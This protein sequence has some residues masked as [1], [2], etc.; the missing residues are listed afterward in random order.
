MCITKAAAAGGV[1]AAQNYIPFPLAARPSPPDY[2]DASASASTVIGAT[3]DFLA[4][5]GQ[6]VVSTG[7]AKAGFAALADS[8]D[9][10][11]FLG[12]GMMLIQGAKAAYDGISQ[13]VET[14]N[15]CMGGD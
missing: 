15:Q 7:L 2:Q 1:A 10:V 13:Y 5:G 8:V 4:A 12:E 14:Y 9:A 6:A 11:P 3:T